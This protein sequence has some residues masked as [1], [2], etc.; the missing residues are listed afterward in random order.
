MKTLVLGIGNPILSDDSVG[1]RVAEEIRKLV[2]DDEVTVIDACTGGLDLLDF[3]AGYD[4]AYIIDAVKTPGGKAGSIYRLQPEA[5]NSTRFATSPHDVNFATALE[6]GKQ[7]GLKLPSDID[8]FAVEVLDTETFSEE[9]TP[10]VEK[11][12]QK[13]AEMVVREIGEVLFNVTQT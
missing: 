4:R 2:E 11:A 7:L 8:I 10:E 13:C 1:I 12:I 9:C 6:L 3:L 5:F